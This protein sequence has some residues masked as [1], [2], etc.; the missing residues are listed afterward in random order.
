MSGAFDEGSM[1]LD[2]YR[3]GAFGLR[4]RS[5]LLSNKDSEEDYVS[6]IA[7][8]DLSAPDSNLH[9]PLKPTTVNKHLRMLSR[10]NALSSIRAYVTSSTMRNMTVTFF[11]FSVVAAFQQ[12][13]LRVEH[14][15]TVNPSPRDSVELKEVQNQISHA[16]SFDRYPDEYIA[17]AMKLSNIKTPRLLSFGCST[18]RE[19]VTLAKKYFPHGSVYGVDIDNQTLAEAEAYAKEELTMEGRLVTFFNGLNTPIQEF[20]PYDAIFANSVLCRNP[21]KEKGCIINGRVT[22]CSISR[23]SEIYPFETFDSTIARLD[24]S[25]AVG[26]VL[27]IVNSNYEFTDSIISQ[28]YEPLEEMCG[29]NFVPRVNQDSKTIERISDRVCGYKK[30][31]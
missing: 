7:L 15:T 20:G 25:L 31:R 19:A 28:R 17:V 29:G 4:R 24:S 11:F 22:S 14:D 27:A 10:L 18:G 9:S 5:S 2:A 12:W 30:M 16:T 21:V 3:A 6:G 1:G 26:G 8:E 13:G 23:F